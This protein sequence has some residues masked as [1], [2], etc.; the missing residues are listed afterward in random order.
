MGSGWGSPV[1]AGRGSLGSPR[2]GSRLPPLSV[3]RG[4]ASPGGAGH[5]GGLRSPPGRGRRCAPSSPDPRPGKLRGDPTRPGRVRG[6]AAGDGAAVPGGLLTLRP[7]R[8]QVVPLPGEAGWRGRKKKNPTGRRVYKKQPTKRRFWQISISLLFPAPAAVPPTP[9]RPP[10]LPPIRGRGSVPGAGKRRDGSIPIPRWG[11]G[12]KF[13]VNLP[14]PFTA[15]RKGASSPAR[16]PGEERGSVLRGGRRRARRQGDPLPLSPQTHTPGRRRGEA[17]RHRGRSPS[18]CL[19]VR[20]APGR[21]WRAGG[22]RGGQGVVSPAPPGRRLRA[23]RRPRP[24]PPPPCRWAPTTCGP[25]R[26][27]PWELESASPPPP[28]L[29]FPATR[30]APGRRAGGRPMRGA[31]RVAR[32]LNGGRA[33]GGA[34]EGVDGVGEWGCPLPAGGAGCGGSSAGRPGVF[35]GGASSGLPVLSAGILPSAAVPPRR[36]QLLRG[37]LPAL[38]PREL[39]RSEGRASRAVGV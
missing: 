26:A 39:S 20:S 17:R 38:A 2:C 14:L 8:H 36:E 19:A 16:P 33:R 21:R 24:P 11:N 4:G 10:A 6:K 13:A 9:A 3:R 34:G 7:G 23:E 5:R 28:G 15:W 31:R 1:P 29:H 32:G 22:G 37:Q 27:A 25:A 30:G 35:A 18:S 12:A